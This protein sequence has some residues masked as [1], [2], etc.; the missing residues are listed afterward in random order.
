MDY[1]ANINWVVTGQLYKRDGCEC[2]NVLSSFFVKHERKL[3]ELMADWHR[4][5]RPKMAKNKEVTYFYD[6]T[7]KFKGYAIAGQQDFKDVVIQELTRFGWTVRAVDMHHPYE[8]EAKHKY[9]NECLAGVSYPGIRINLDNNEALCVALTNAEVSIGYKGFRKCKSG[10]KLSENAD[11][12]V[13][14]EFRTDGT[15][16]FDTLVLG[17]KFHLTNL[18]GMCAPLPSRR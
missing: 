8:H 14:L 9:I 18:S 12:A 3:R 11:D 10:E 16:A 2:L 13:R 4:Y 7:A 17:V 1:N 6:S 15:D 5:Y